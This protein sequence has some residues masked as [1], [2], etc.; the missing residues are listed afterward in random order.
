M[1]KPSGARNFMSSFE[2]G[3]RRIKDDH[4]PRGYRE[5]RSPAAMRRLVAKKVQ[6]QRNTCPYCKWEFTDMREVGPDHIEPRG[7]GASRRDDHPDN[8]QAMHNICNSL[9]GSKRL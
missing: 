2:P 7:M 5:L 3:V 9:K 8:I 1:E 6:E 4:H